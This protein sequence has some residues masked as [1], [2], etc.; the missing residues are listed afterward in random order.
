LDEGK[1][2]NVRKG[3]RGERT[4]EGGAEERGK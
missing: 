2:G 1:R 4:K 3:N